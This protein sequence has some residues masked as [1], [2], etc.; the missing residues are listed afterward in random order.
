MV[1]IMYELLIVKGEAN[2]E[3]KS[4]HDCRH[5]KAALSWWCTHKKAIEERGTALPGVKNCP[6]W[7]PAKHINELSWFEKLFRSKNYI[8]IELE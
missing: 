4:C 5:C 2:S 1:I 7:E 3:R 8:Q 6:H